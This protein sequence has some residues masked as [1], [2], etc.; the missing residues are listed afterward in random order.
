MLL[1]R[2][3]ATADFLANLQ[4]RVCSVLRISGHITRKNDALAEY[5]DSACLFS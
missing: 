4:D 3:R 1:R 2:F 5:L